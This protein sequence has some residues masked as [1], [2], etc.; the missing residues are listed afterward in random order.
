MANGPQVSVGQ[1]GHMD[2][3]AD[4]GPVRRRIGVAVDDQRLAAA[5]RHIA[6]GGDQ[7]PL[8]TRPAAGPQA[9]IGSRHIEGADRDE[10]GS[11]HRLRLDKQGLGVE[12]ALAIGVQRQ[13]RGGLGHALIV[14]V[15]INGRRRAEDE[16]RHVQFDRRPDQRPRFFDIVLPVLGW[17]AHGLFDTDRRGEV[18]DGVEPVLAH[19]PPDGVPVRRLRHDERRVLRW[20]PP[21]ARR[22]VIENCERDA[23]IAACPREA[24][25]DIPGP[26]SNQNAPRHTR[27][28]CLLSCESIPTAAAQI[29]QDELLREWSF[30]GSPDS[31]FGQLSDTARMAPEYERHSG[32][33]A[34]PR[35]GLVRS[36]GGIW[37][38][39]LVTTWTS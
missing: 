6:T 13:G 25:A 12:L 14:H 5:R 38:A 31:T 37:G 34:S 30:P 3:I 39:P 29:I 20:S 10:T 24:G 8:A 22:K 26:A 21:I 33:L 27:N 36:R 9:S 16:I 19:E 7:V 17:I 2:E 1:V 15:A 11:A 4:A 35:R 23:R 18:H 32:R 28:F